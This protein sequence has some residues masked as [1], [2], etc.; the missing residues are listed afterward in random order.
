MHDHGG[1][2]NI[3][4]QVKGMQVMYGHKTACYENMD[5]TGNSGDE[6]SESSSGVFWRDILIFILI[7]IS[8]NSDGAFWLLVQNLAACANSASGNISSGAF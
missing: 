4:R 2:N 3:N 8:I 6:S 5:D 7:F 1:Q